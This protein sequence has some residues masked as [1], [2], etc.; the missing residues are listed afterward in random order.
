VKVFRLFRL[1]RIVLVF[2]V[3]TQYVDVQHLTSL[4]GQRVCDALFFQ[5]S[6][7]AGFGALNLFF[8]LS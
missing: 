1:E 2:G 3:W 5:A 8:Q 7:F 6:G 4:Q